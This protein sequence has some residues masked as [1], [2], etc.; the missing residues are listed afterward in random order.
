MVE[1]TIWEPRMIIDR[2]ALRIIMIVLCIVMV[3]AAIANVVA[4]YERDQRHQA[5]QAQ[6]EALRAQIERTGQE[7]ERTKKSIDQRK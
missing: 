6:I 3:G 4:M 2:R 7:I 1:K 5:L